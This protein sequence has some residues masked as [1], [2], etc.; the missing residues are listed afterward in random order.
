MTRSNDFASRL[1]DK[2]PF[3]KLSGSGNDFAVLDNRDGTF[4]EAGGWL[5]T[6]VCSRRYSVG[7]DGLI[8]IENAPSASFRVRFFNPDGNEFNTCG[9][10]GRCAVRYVFLNGIADRKM[11]MATNIGI[12]DAEVAGD[13]VKLRLLGPQEIRL[14]VS[15]L[16][17][18]KQ[19]TGHLVQ[20][21]DPHYVVRTEGLREQ[22]FVPLARKISHHEAFGRAG[23]N[24]H[25]I[26]II[27]R[28]KINIRSFERGV[29][30]ETLACGSGCTATAVAVY[31]TGDCDPPV[32]FTPQ[33]GIPLTVHFHPEN[34]F[35]DLY[36]EGDA[37]L[38]YRGELTK[39][40]LNG[41]PEIDVS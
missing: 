10:G 30:D 35:Q 33:S 27:S 38:I 37:R 17:E 1:P 7:A 31:S 41:F 20:M 29:E 5:A 32:R 26:E 28:N 19:F 9:N 23:T 3:S 13:S 15:I 21:G 4:T 18:G 40:A 22:A 6:R 14:N 2:I 39:E 16:L 12:V 11:T 25:F 24:V 36:L 8:L 34:G